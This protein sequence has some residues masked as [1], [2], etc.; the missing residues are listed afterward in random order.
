[1]NIHELNLAWSYVISLRLDHYDGF[2]S[3]NRSKLMAK[4]KDVVSKI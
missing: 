3:L 4:K 2:V 1:M